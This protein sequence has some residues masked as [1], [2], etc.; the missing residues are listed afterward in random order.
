MDRS[1]RR[2]AQPPD[3]TVLR[4][5]VSG[6]DWVDRL[7][8]APQRLTVSA[9]A[10]GVLGPVTEALRARGYEPVGV[11][12]A[13]PVPD[14]TA[15]VDVLVPARVAA[16]HPAWWSDASGAADR[17]L[18]TAMGPVAVILRNLLTVHRR[19]GTAAA[20]RP[21]TSAR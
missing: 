4:F 11:I 19:G 14:G 9:T 12:A 17:G 2:T 6:P 18:S 3:A 15:A 1:T 8:V 20:R 13:G 5:F 21:S 7:P 10:E 16:T